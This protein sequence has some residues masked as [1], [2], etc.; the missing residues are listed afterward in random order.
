L[1]LQ[2]FLYMSYNKWDDMSMAIHLSIVWF[3]YSIVNVRSG[4]VFNYIT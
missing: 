4:Y 2:I 3:N 1:A